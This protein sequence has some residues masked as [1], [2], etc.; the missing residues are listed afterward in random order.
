MAGVHPWTI[1]TGLTPEIFR[2]AD[3]PYQDLHERVLDALIWDPDPRYGEALRV[4]EYLQGYAVQTGR[5]VLRYGGL[6][7]LDLEW[8]QTVDL[9]PLLGEVLALVRSAHLL[10]HNGDH[11][12][13]WVL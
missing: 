13:G 4:V 2:Q 9:P 6:E 12:I 11:R 3:I 1:R 5:A 8:T 7:L 10:V